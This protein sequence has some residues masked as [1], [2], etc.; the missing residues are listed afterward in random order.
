MEIKPMGMER[1]LHS[2]LVSRFI[3][4]G[5]S[6]PV[7]DDECKKEVDH[8]LKGILKLNDAEISEWDGHGGILRVQY[9]GSPQ[10]TSQTGKHI[11]SCVPKE[12]VEERTCPSG[13]RL[14]VRAF[15]S[16]VD[17]T[18]KGDDAILFSC[19]G[20]KRGHIF[21][22]RRAITSGMF[23]EDEAAKIRATAAKTKQEAERV[24]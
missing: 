24:G 13:H 1:E 15:E 5:G 4:Y 16:Y 20:G 18:K 23:T 21:S 17:L 12:T 19:P 2:Y 8:I 9:K 7:P 11:C 22:L 6:E 14:P 3:N 10:M